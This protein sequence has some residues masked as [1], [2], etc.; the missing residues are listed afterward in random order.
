MDG[1]I[2]DVNDQ[3]MNNNNINL[4]DYVDIY[5]MSMLKQYII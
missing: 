1:S 5:I 2:P 3:L 4:L